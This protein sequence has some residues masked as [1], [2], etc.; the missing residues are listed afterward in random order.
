MSHIVWAI[1]ETDEWRGDYPALTQTFLHENFRGGEGI[2][3]RSSP[4]ERYAGL[5]QGTHNGK[6][7]IAVNLI[8]IAEITDQRRR[9]LARSAYGC[10]RLCQT[11][12][13][14][15]YPM[16]RE[17][18]SFEPGLHLGAV[19]GRIIQGTFDSAICRGVRNKHVY[20]WL[21]PSK[22]CTGG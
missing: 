13:R 10:E 11:R 3:G 4:R 9:S 21:P 6:T 17:V 8:A 18:Q 12:N 20:F 16:P 1:A 7:R 2:K 22:G 19:R 15:W 5:L 14:D